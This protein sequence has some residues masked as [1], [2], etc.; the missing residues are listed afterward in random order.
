VCNA[1]GKENMMELPLGKVIAIAELK[2][3]ILMTPEYIDQQTKTT[4][5]QNE[6]RFGYWKI[7][8]YAWILES[9]QAI[10]PM[11]A[12]G[13]QRLWEWAGEIA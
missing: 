11:P 2:D 7:G 6:L 4:Q 3:C 9:V 5:G 8:R 1:I 12:R 13:Q 10:E